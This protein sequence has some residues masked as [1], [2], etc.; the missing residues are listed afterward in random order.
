M[1]N[2]KSDSWCKMLVGGLLV[3][4]VGMLLGAPRTAHAWGSFRD[5]LADLVGEYNTH[6]A[7]DLLAW[8][9]LFEEL[10]PGAMMNFPRQWSIFGNDYVIVD[11]SLHQLPG[12]TGP[13]YEPYGGRGP[14]T[15]FSSHYRNAT[16]QA[17]FEYKNLIAD[18][19]S[20]SPRRSHSA[21]WAAHFLAD[22]YVPYHNLGVLYT[23]QSALSLM[24]DV[25]RFPLQ[26]PS[27][28]ITAAE[29]AP[30]GHMDWYDPSYWD[31]TIN[32][33]NSTHIRWERQISYPSFSS[34]G[35]DPLWSNSAP[36]PMKNF[37]AGV[38]SLTTS[39]FDNI[40]AN[41]QQAARDAARGVYTAW[42]STLSAFELKLNVTN[43]DS[44]D[45]FIVEAGVTYNDK[46]YNA[47][48]VQAEITLPPGLTTTDPAKQLVNN[49][50]LAVKDDLKS[51]KWKVSGSSEGCPEIK[52]KVTGKL[53]GDIPD[54]AAML[55]GGIEATVLPPPIVEIT[56]PAA[57]STVTQTKVTVTGTISDEASRVWIEVNGTDK[58]W[59]SEG[60]NSGATFSKEIPLKQGVNS[61]VVKAVNQCKKEGS[62][63]ISVTGNFTEPAIRVVMSWD[64][65][66]TDVD[67]HLTDSNGGPECYYSNMHPNWGD[68]NTDTDDP[69]L[70]IDNRFGYGPETI[71]LPDPKPGSYTVR[72]VYYSDHN[73]ET[74]IPSFVTIKVY[75]YGLLKGT[76]T[77]TL[78]DTGATWEGIY[79]FVIS[80]TTRAL[81]FSAA[82]FTAADY[83]VRERR[84]TTS[85]AATQPAINGNQIVWTYARNAYYKQIF[86]YNLS[87]SKESPVSTADLTGSFC[88]QGGAAIGETAIVWEEDCL[89]TPSLYSYNLSS[90]VEAK[91]TSADTLG[92]SRIAVSGDKLVWEDIRNG[93]DAGGNSDI[94]LRNLSDGTERRITTNEADQLAPAISGDRIV[95][96]D[97][98]Y[99]G[100]TIFMYDLALST[101]QQIARASTGSRNPPAID[102]HLIVWEDGRAGNGDIYMYDLDTHEERQLT[103][104]LAEQITPD[105]SGGKVV[106]V[107][108]RNGNA[109]IYMYDVEKGVE[110]PICT[111][112]ADQ[113][114]PRISGNR[115]VW[116][117]Y[118]NGSPDIYMAEINPTTNNDIGLGPGWNLISL[119]QQPSDTAISNVLGA[120]S[121]KYSSTWAFQNGSWKVFD[122]ASPGFSD[123][124]TMEVGW[125]YWLN[126]TE[127]ATLSVTG[128]EPSKTI[129]LITG[130]NLVGYN[131]ST[132]QNITDALASITGKV[133]SVWAYKNDSWQF[134]DPANPGF[135]DLTTMSPGY[136]Y[137]INTN[138]AC[139]W[140]LP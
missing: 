28:F 119:P 37:V 59:I 128:A 29:A 107:D 76:F 89:Y 111:N 10:G 84:I 71:I 1:S 49:G 42:R 88:L 134:Y 41:G 72:V 52:V 121:G 75:E 65:N 130:W 24:V 7:L 56:S 30:N 26:D 73:S 99:G 74:A 95:W 126:M 91:E 137:W 136:G 109:D 2:H 68:P 13:D 9:R 108:Y 122:P 45:S 140:T 12:S 35:I 43:S 131:S 112:T 132:S 36:E 19:K 61:I 44:P 116:T 105:V 60:Y 101:E 139:T 14:I 47:N 63:K 138:G 57:G 17:N 127:A 15:L 38:Q 82:D 110:V 5:T 31:S 67:L 21:A 103:T 58:I 83:T 20:K 78:P 64:T 114:E 125:G 118:R 85:G 55:N 34:P 18:M 92:N 6:A 117:D 94:Y 123:L 113:R 46:L 25:L 66:G 39:D 90:G 33:N 97:T 102:G 62:A 115:I 81:R 69:L 16:I 22:Q 80:P 100:Y 48:T 129:N 32:T 79:T 106:W 53:D 8:D 54:A 50:V 4:V 77:Q 3:L 133:V 23:G 120:I 93:T 27:K 104:N 124:S 86:R 96:T 11:N 51:V 98:R 87:T 135:S 70:D 40:V